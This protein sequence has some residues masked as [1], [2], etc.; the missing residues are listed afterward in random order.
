MLSKRMQLNMLH[1]KCRTPSG[2]KGL[3]CHGLVLA[4]MI[5]GCGCVPD[6]IVKSPAQK[7]GKFRA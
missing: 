3:F 2:C 6:G 5:V 4:L 7:D 1:S